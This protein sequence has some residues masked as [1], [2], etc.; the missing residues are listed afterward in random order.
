MSH[1]FSLQFHLKYI[2][3]LTVLNTLKVHNCKC[4]HRMWQWEVNRGSREAHS[5]LTPAGTW[6]DTS[7]RITGPLPGE[8]AL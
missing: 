1:Q 8:G 2:R 3:A 7:S 6:G 4:T 5:F